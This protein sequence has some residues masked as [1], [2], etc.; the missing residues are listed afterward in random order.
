ML[1]NAKTAFIQSVQIIWIYMV[2]KSVFKKYKF[3]TKRE[4]VLAINYKCYITC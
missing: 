3:F 2:K 1:E 4:N